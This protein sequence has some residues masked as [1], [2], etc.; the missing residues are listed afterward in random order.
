MKRIKDF[1]L[2]HFMLSDTL[3]VVSCFYLLFCI[4]SKLKINYIDR[5]IFDNAERLYPVFFNSCITLFGFLITGISII[6]IFLKD[7]KLKPL[8][9]DGHF[10][11]I[12]A[13]YFNAIGF[14]S[15]FGVI[16]FCGLVTEK[17]LILSQATALI[18]FIFLAR[19]ARCIWIIKEI[20]AII[21]KKNSLS[22]S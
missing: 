16:S 15:L 1:F 6:I 17:N 4:L 11:S 2:I 21:Y 14:C 13:I 7:D 12:L 22:S 5:L 19:L 9:E 10:Q 18:M 20:T 8:E 3:L